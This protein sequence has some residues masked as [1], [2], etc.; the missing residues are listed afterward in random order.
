MAVKAGSILRTF[1][2]YF[3]SLEKPVHGVPA[4]AAVLEAELP[5]STN[6]A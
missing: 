4:G 2:Y 1:L 3:D 5:H 6:Q